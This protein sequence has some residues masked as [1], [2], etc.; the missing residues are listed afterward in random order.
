MKAAKTVDEKDDKKVDKTVLTLAGTTVFVKA[1]GLAWTWVG[2]KA[3]IS[4][5]R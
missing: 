3:Y 4:A 2:M 1:D 5:E